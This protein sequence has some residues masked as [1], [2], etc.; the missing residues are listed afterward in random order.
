[1]RTRNLVALLENESSSNFKSSSL[2]PSPP[3][4]LPP[5]PPVSSQQH[6]PLLSLPGSLLALQGEEEGQRTLPPL[7]PSL[8]PSLPHL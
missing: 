3:P 4:S 7:P 2:P 6:S 1:M 5:S 8:P